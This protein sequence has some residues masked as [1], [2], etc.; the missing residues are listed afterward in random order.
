MF[1]RISSYFS[2]L[3]ACILLLGSCF[4][5]PAADT[6]R[7]RRSPSTEELGRLWPSK[8]DYVPPGFRSA[9]DAKLVNVTVSGKSLQYFD[10]IELADA[11]EQS[12]PVRFCLIYDAMGTRPFYMMENKVWNDL[13]Q[14]FE[15]AE[16]DFK[17]DS[18]WEKIANHYATQ[19]NLPTGKLP[20]FD[21]RFERAR[22]FAR[23][24]KGDLPTK[25]QWDRAAGWQPDKQQT[26]GPY[27]LP[28]P[29]EQLDVNVRHNAPVEVMTGKCDVGPFGVRQM[30]GNGKEWTRDEFIEN[31]MMLRGRS[32]TALA[33]LPYAE[34]T[35]TNFASQP[36]A[37]SSPTISFRVAIEIQ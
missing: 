24:L 11:A 18:K 13:F 32:F 17:P 21:V 6:V 4:H 22:Q 19:Q 9:K 25:E 35:P 34:F 1:I 16:P 26:G 10:R 36:A 30:A 7:I 37:A 14:R 8:A 28:Q 29:G 33:P 5:V 2:T 12:L 20:V 23:W 3:I 15:M 27:R 31:D